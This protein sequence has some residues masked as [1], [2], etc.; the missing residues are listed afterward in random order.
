M[1]YTYL[2]RRGDTG[3][4][5]Y[6]G[7]GQGSRSKSTANRNVWW[8][9]VVDR[10]GFRAEVLATWVAE[11]DA[12]EHERLLI[13]C[14]RDLGAPLVNLTE[15]GD[16]VSGYRPTD[17]VRAKISRAMRARRLSPEHRARIAAANSRRVVTEDT[18][19]KL[20]ARVVSPETR[21]RMSLAKKRA[22]MTTA[23]LAQLAA[24][25]QSKRGE[26]SA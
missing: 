7:K 13:A 3:A 14:F 24:A 20:R 4:V 1:F 5:F 9:R 21:A 23:R 12:L 6:I 17:E 11:S 22:P 8:H 26:L 15:G 18:K 16:G 10:V 19:E 2:H 25:R